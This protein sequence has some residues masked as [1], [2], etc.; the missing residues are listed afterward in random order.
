M[1]ADY[2]RPHAQTM[3]ELFKGNTAHYGV[4]I[5]EKAEVA[6]GEKAAGESFTKHGAIGFTQ[7]QKHL[8]GIQSI[9]VV[10]IDD[11]GNLRFAAID[12]DVYPSNP[13]RY[14]SLLRRWGL[15]FV[16]F[17]TKSKGLHL[18]VFF[19]EDTPVSK[20]LPL[21]HAVRRL[22]GLPPDTEVF[23]KQK[24]LVPGQTGNWIN[25]PYYAQGD[26]TR[27]AYDDN[28]EDMPLAEGLAHAMMHRT[29][30]AALQDIIESLPFFDGPPC[31]Q[32]LYIGDQI[33]KGA[34]NCFLFNCAT[35]TKAKYGEDFAEQL[36][37]INTGIEEPLPYTEVDTTVVSSHNKGD[38]SYQ[39]TDGTLQ[40]VC[41]R[42]ECVLRTFGKGSS[43][44][45]DLSFEQ[46]TQVNSSQP[47]YKWVVSGVTMTFYS[48]GELMKQDRF[49]AMCMRFL[50]KIP[51]M[52]KAN[53]WND[54]LNRAFSNV[55]VEE[56][57][58][59]DE[60]SDAS[61]WWDKASE[62][63]TSR[64]ATRPSQ[65]NQGLVWR[66]GTV[67]YFKGAKLR[68]HVEK[69]NM[70][71]HFK[72]MQHR[73]MLQSLGGKSCKLRCSDTNKSTR[74]WCIDLDEAHENGKLESV[75]LTQE[76]SKVEALD[77]KEEAF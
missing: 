25:L 41:D 1:A 68:E 10:P 21:V 20:V 14:I 43:E 5:P 50:H 2:I 52:M 74:A 18:Y 39:C 58:D 55:V 77:F 59:V 37:L 7:Y 49:R 53:A 47:Y 40:A 69:S 27:P 11:A 30:V 66:E 67:L 31:L 12:V 8:H 44:V 38:Y 70:F 33:G 13:M 9:G 24:T 36:H 28:G 26:G 64:P 61:V 15:P 32:A 57:E 71:R 16:P 54:I 23:P 42:Q 56:V 35:Y 34:R 17:R 3:Q 22:L 19:A 75:P 48:E 45:S 51:N 72:Q 60:M 62:F 65:I 29:T 73:D 46:L 63:F 4:H 76:L 6:E